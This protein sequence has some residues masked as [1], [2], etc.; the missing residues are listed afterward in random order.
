MG[1]SG[2]F[3]K[4]L[5]GEMMYLSFVPAPL[6]P[7]PTIEMDQEMNAL[8]I[9][10][11]KEIAILDTLAKNVPDMNLYISM[12]IR[13]EAVLS[14]QIEGTQAT[15]ED[16]FDPTISA[17]VNHDVRDVVR[18]IL[19]SEYAYTRIQE[20][21]LSNRLLKEIHK[22][23]LSEGRGEEKNPGEFRT[24]QNWLGPQGSSLKNATYI[25]PNLR[26][27]KQALGEWEKFL[28]EEESELDV[29]EKLA[30]IHY[31]FE[32]IHPFLDGNGRVGRMLLNLYLL[33]EKVLQTP[34]LYL[35]YF[36]KQNRV[37]YYD[38]MMEVRKKGNYEQWVK[39][40]LRIII[41]T[42]S[43][44]TEKIKQLH[45]LHQRNMEV[46]ENS[47]RTREL[48]KAIFAYLESSP[49][50]EVKQT[51]EKFGLTYGRV[52][53]AVKRLEEFKILK[54]SNPQRRNRVYSYAAYLDILNDE[55]SNY[56]LS[57]NL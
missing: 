37:E 55:N 25:P 45:A 22:I 27:M 43:D 1:R 39:F 49:I 29:L 50:I 38:R 16:I 52:N 51:A 48:L 17:N 56:F 42:A 41:E 46:L 40:F 18:Y 23:L 10:A 31:Q 54:Q 47:G 53:N 32:T 5:S 9:Q 30:L 36:L 7:E 33:Q 20:L 35:S 12:Y 14:S 11:H 57:E 19:A 6:P 26:D 15:F 2:Y 3:K 4:N 34:V 13:K 8:L 44:G 24:S 21:P 28:H